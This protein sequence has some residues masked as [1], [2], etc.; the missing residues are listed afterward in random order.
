MN[1]DLI[2]FPVLIQVLLTL[3]VFIRLGQVKEQAVKR[4]EVDQTRRALHDDAWP[5]YVLKVNNNIR[6]Q[7]ETPVLFYVLVIGLW[8]LG[9]ATVTAQLLALAYALLRLAH[10]SVHLG[11]NIVKVRKRIFQASIVALLLLSGLLLLA[12]GGIPV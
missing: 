7:F 9:A 11:S 3:F 4:G 12:L 6:N 2:F 1:P 10:A 5:D 8:S